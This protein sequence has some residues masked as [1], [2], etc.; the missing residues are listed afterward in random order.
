M[1]S[2]RT[3]ATDKHGF[4]REHARKIAQTP[5]FIHKNVLEQKQ[6]SRQAKHAFPSHKTSAGFLATPSGR[7]RPFHL[8]TQER[9]G[10]NLDCGFGYFSTDDACER[11]D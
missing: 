7:H 3:D 8:M 1:G 6:C 10:S 4:L 2:S 9:C 5:A 11:P